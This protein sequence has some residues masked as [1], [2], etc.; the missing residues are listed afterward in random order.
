[1]A[2]H[3]AAGLSGKPQALHRPDIQDG[4]QQ[5]HPAR[6]GRGEAAGP[7]PAYG[8]ELY[9]R[10]E[11]G[12][13]LRPAGVSGAPQSFRKSRGPGLHPAQ[14]LRPLRAAPDGT[15][16]DSPARRSAGNRAPGSGK[17]HFPGV[18]G[19]RGPVYRNAPE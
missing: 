6:H 5:P 8:P 13:Q 11:A 1:M 7:P 16:R 12:P 14:S 2:R 4:D 10:P 9:Q 3:L 18:R 15:G 19:N 17:G